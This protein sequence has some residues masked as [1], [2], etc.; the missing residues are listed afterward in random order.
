[1]ELQWRIMVARSREQAKSNDYA[2]QFRR[3][4]R[5]NVLGSKG[6][7]LQAKVRDPNGQIDQLAS[8]AIEDH[9]GRFGARGVSEVTGKLTFLKASQMALDSACVDGELCAVIYEG[10]GEHGIQVQLVDPIR[11]DVDHNRVGLPGGNF[12]R[13]SIE[14]TPL[15]RPVAYYFTALDETS[16]TYYS[17]NGVKYVRVPAE[18]VIHEFLPEQ[19][20]QKRGY[21]WMSTPLQRL[22]MLGGYE[23]AALVAARVGAAKMGVLKPGEDA[24][25]AEDEPDILTD[26]EPGTFWVAPPGW[27]AQPFAHDYPTGEFAGFHK[28]CLRGISAGLGVA[29]N[30]LANDLEGVNFSSIRQGTLDER[31]TYKDLQTWLAEVWHDRIYDRWL[32][33]QLLRGA[34]TVAGKPLKIERF[35]KYRAV[36]W[37]GRRWQWVD[38]KADQEAAVEAVD[39]RIQS[40]TQV[41]LDQGRDPADVE[42]ELQAEEAAADARMLARIQTVQAQCEK[43]NKANKDL[44]LHWSQIIAIGGASTAPGAFLAGVAQQGQAA[45]QQTQAQAIAKKPATGAAS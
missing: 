14:Y 2:K 15:G 38:P 33:L 39:N 3:L 26:A 42:A 12:I 31:E 10:V 9:W 37:Q 34:I 45:A 18:N 1:V 21:P 40:R 30:N 7:Q 41:I 25:P 13:F 19:V 16:E 43:L 20:G 4:L 32:M 5:V 24:E 35:D 6:I 17:Y 36:T 23:Q 44:N 22:Q 27:E 29:Y 28:A 11:L 8:Q